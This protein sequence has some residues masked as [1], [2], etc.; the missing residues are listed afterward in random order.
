MNWFTFVFLLYLLTTVCTLL[1]TIL[2]AL[3]IYN[4]DVNFHAD[5]DVKKA[6]IKLTSRVTELLQNVKNFNAVRRSCLGGANLVA[7]ISKNIMLSNNPNELFDYLATNTPYWSWV[8]IRLLEAMVTASEIQAAVNLIENYK[9]VI[10]G[11]KLKD[12]LPDILN[13]ELKEVYYT[14]IVSKIKMNADEITVAVLLKYRLQLEEVIMDIKKGTLVLS[15]VKKGCIEVYWYIPNCYVDTAYKNA[16]ENCHKFH[17]FHLVQLKIGNNKALCV[18][19][20][21]INANIAISTDTV[22]DQPLY[23]AYF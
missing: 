4:D 6:F 21:L 19:G 10:Y 5:D 12:V 17:L 15:N 7:E 22:R 1:F 16:V 8:D 23:Y 9:E 18:L 20:T 11:K 2:A 3:C 13:K 14:R